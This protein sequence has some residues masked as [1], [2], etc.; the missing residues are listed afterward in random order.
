MIT[1]IFDNLAIATKE[2]YQIKLR[3]D[4]PSRTS[5]SNSTGQDFLKELKKHN[6]DLRSHIDNYR[7][8]INLIYELRE[9]T[10]HRE[11]FGDIGYTHN[12]R[13][14]WY[15]KINND[16]VCSVKRC[17]DKLPFNESLS[18]WGIIKDPIFT[19]L[20]PFHFVKAAGMKLAVFSDGYLRLLGFSKFVDTLSP[21]DSYIR[22]MK[23]FEEYRLGTR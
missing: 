6:P 13:F 16:I 5:L 17:G 14:T 21:S 3:Y 1:G 10:I 7:E 9:V 4:H 2:K 12:T 23:M 18:N 8:F 19:L 22:E 15:F 20:E 11:G